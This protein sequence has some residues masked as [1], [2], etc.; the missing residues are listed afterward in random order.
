M[1]APTVAH[2]SGLSLSD[3]RVVPRIAAMLVWLAMCVPAYYLTRLLRMPNRVP[4]AFLSGIARI[5]GIRVRTDGVPASGR[6]I[7]IANHV[8]WMDI[9][10][11]ARVSGAAF[12]AHDGLA[13]VGPLK[14]LCDMND[15]VFIARSRRQ[16]VGEQAD[17]IRDALDVSH[18]LVLFPEG[19]TANGHEMLPLK[20]AL[21]SA[22]DPVPPGVSVQP[23]FMDYGP[24]AP[25]VCWVGDEPGLHN[26][27]RI[28]AGRTPVAVT[29]RFLTPLSGDALDGRKAM[30]RAAQGALTEALDRSHAR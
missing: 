15:T 20:S 6:R 28:V 8:S 19:T 25:A 11:L 13:G 17:S 27:L 9:L 24:D 16:T 3:W 5:A 26:F 22:I 14:W 2:G 23:V 21:L 12:V 30:T 18:T 7:L 1:G 29:V 10:V 4:P